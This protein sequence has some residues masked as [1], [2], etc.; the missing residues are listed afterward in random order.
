MGGMH[1][2]DIGA[3]RQAKH[4]QRLSHRHAHAVAIAS[5][6]CMRVRGPIA[7]PHRHLE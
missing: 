5:Q 4:F 3:V 6:H 7:R 1:G 2:C